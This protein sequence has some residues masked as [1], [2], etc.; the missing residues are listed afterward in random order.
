MNV[1]KY[2]YNIEKNKRIKKC[3][4]LQTQNTY[5]KNSKQKIKENQLNNSQPLN[6]LKSINNSIYKDKE[7]KKIQINIYSKPFKIANGVNTNINNIRSNYIAILSKNKNK[8]LAKNKNKDYS[9]INL[10]N[11]LYNTIDLG[12]NAINF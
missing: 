11:D 12:R 4:Y 3:S 5:N 10:S 6:N 2:Q 7:K 8:D 1:R 9:L